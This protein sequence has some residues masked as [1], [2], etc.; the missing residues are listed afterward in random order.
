MISTSVSRAH[1]NLLADR[2]R[3]RKVPA[4]KCVVDHD[5]ERSAHS[6]VGRVFA[7]V[8]MRA[9]G[10]EVAVTD[11]NHCRAR[12]VFAGRHGPAGNIEAVALAVAPERGILH[13]GH[14]HDAR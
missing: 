11:V 13:G 3:S 7:A 14:R 9:D 5:D 12:R 8:H 6:I 2:S 1:Q 10:G 4:R